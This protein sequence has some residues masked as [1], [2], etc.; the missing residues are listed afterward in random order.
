MYLHGVWYSILQFITNSITAR[1]VY[2]KS[3]LERKLLLGVHYSPAF[4][5][6]FKFTLFKYK[7]HM[8][9]SQYKLLFNIYKQLSFQLY[10]ELIPSLVIIN[11]ILVTDSVNWSGIFSA[12]IESASFYS[13]FSTC[14]VFTLHHIHYS[15][16]DKPNALKFNYFPEKITTH[17]NPLPILLLNIYK[18]T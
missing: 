2:V 7:H 17:K 18:K 8:Q 16:K 13:H 1:H 12:S 3:H 14:F 10:S 4:T 15:T 11:E 9:N 6:K 5:I